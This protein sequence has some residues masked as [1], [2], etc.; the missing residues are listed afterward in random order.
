MMRAD[1]KNAIIRMFHVHKRFG[2]KQ[3]IVDISLD[4]L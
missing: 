1:D 4:I 3:A 2:S